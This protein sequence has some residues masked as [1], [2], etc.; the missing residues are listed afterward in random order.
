MDR[1]LETYQDTQAFSRQ[2]CKPEIKSNFISRRHLGASSPVRVYPQTTP[3]ESTLMYEPTK[4]L[5]LDPRHFNQDK[6]SNDIC[7][8]SLAETMKD[9]KI[10]NDTIQDSQQTRHDLEMQLQ[11]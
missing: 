2:P 8:N 3:M 7:L 1:H 9:C 5:N 6:F 4:N 11:S 10:V